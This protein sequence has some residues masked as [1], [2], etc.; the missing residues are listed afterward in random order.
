VP[1]KPFDDRQELAKAAEGGSGRWQGV[2]GG[3]FLAVVTTRGEGGGRELRSTTPGLGGGNGD[4]VDRPAVWVQAAGRAACT[5][6][7]ML[8]G[9]RQPL[10]GCRRAVRGHRWLIRIEAVL[11]W[12]ASVQAGGRSAAMVEA[13]QGLLSWVL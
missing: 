12:R 8:G 4:Q 3:G 1:R 11:L 9:T 7:P 5:R 13:T 6:V 10:R 2:L